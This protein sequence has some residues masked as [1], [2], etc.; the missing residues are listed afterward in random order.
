MVDKTLTCKLKGVKIIKPH[1]FYDDRGYFFESY[2]KKESFIKNINFVQDNE[3]FS[4]R[5]TIR[6]LHY[7]IGESS[8]SKLIRVI[9]GKIKDVIIDLRY[10]SNT[11]LDFFEIILSDENKTQL[12]V[13]KGFAHGFSVLSEEAIVS[14]KVDNYYNKE[15]ERCI[16]PV[17]ENLWFDWDIDKTD[18]L[19]SP[20]DKEGIDMI[21]FEDYDWIFYKNNLEFRK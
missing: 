12:F 3:S 13:P 20:K 18:I 4:K 16:N 19:L 7:Q 15:S 21:E 10:D 11:Y 5:G 1:I 6:G 14:Y 17:S 9:K 2:N 8:Q